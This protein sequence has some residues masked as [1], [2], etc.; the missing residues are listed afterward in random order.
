MNYLKKVYL[1][2]FCDEDG[3]LV[4]VQFPNLSGGLTI[5]FII[6]GRI[7]SDG[8]THSIFRG[9]AAVTGL[10]WAY[11]E[12]RYGDNYFRRGL[13]LVVAIMIIMELV[14]NLL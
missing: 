11:L 8:L 3:R 4:I 7:F 13:G 14:R 2:T 6:L 5:G 10:W 12:I 1:K 9:A